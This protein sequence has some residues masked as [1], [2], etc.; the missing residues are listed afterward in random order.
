MYYENHPC[1]DNGFIYPSPDIHVNFTYP[2]HVH[3]NYEF[4]YVEE[5]TLFA[6]I[7]GSVQQLSAGD[8]ALVLSNQPHSYTTPEHSKSWT[9]IFSPD[10]I[11]ELK[12]IIAKKGPLSP[13]IHLNDPTVREMCLKNKNNVL[14][15]RAF[16]YG[17]AST[18]CAGEPAPHL[19]SE[20]SDAA[21]KIIQ[22][23]CDHYSEPL[24]LEE[25]SRTLGY[26]YRYLSGL[27]NKFYNQPFSAIINRHR[28]YRARALLE[29]GEDSI[30]DIAM[31]CGFGSTRSFNRNFKL[32]LGITPKE[33]KQKKRME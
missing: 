33:Y 25:I 10:L 18:Y 2:L 3:K 12:Q 8:G 7:G 11:P 26:N 4:I 32:V 28:I 27:I 30:T 6:E 22:Y 1:S 23:V 19:V 14:Q 20:D 21:M 16:L 15:M 31:L 17:L 13:I 9:L 24:T 5:G 29:K